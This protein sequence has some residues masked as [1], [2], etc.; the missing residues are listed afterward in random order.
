[1]SS[2]RWKEITPSQ[3][4]WEREALAFVRERLP[5][6]E[7]YRAWSNFEFIAQDGSIYEVDLLVLTPKGFFLVEIKSRPGT[8]DG[9]AGT[10][11]WTDGGRSIVVDNPL[12]L[13][14][15]KAK[16]LAT[17]LRNQRAVDRIPQLPFLGAVMFLSGNVQCRL[18]G[19]ARQGAHLRDVDAADGRPD[20]PGI[21]A[22][23]AYQTPEEFR[24]QRLRIDRPMAKAISLA[25]EQAGI[26]PS[27]KYR[28]V[29]DFQLERALGDGPGYQD[30]EAK[31][32]A[33]RG[34][35]RRVRLYTAG[36]TLDREAV[37]R[38]ADR[39]MRLLEGIEHPGIL[40]PV[41]YHVHELG[42][43]LVFEHDPKAV[44]L[45]H[46]VHQQAA[47]L[48]IDLRLHLVREIAEALRYAHEKRLYHRALNPSSILVRDGDGDRPRIQ[49][50]NWQTAAKD[51]LGSSGHATAT[52]HLADLVEGPATAYLAPEALTDPA[53][54]GEALDVFS[55]GAISFLVL[56]GRAP[57]SSAIELAERV[58]EGKGLRI[59]SALDGAGANLAE[60]IQWAT[61]PSATSRLDSVREFL[62]LLDGVEDELTAPDRGEVKS[63]EEAGVG[64]RLDGGWLVKKRLGRGATAIVFL[65]E[66]DGREVVLKLANDASQNDRIVDEAALLERL[67]HDRIVAYRGATEVAGRKGILMDKAGDE[68]LAQRLRS[69]GP[70]H[71]DL[72]QRFGEDLLEVV[73][74]L[75]EKAIP[76]RDIKP[77]NLGIAPSGSKALHLVL[78]DFS[79]SKTPADRIRAGTVPAS[80]WLG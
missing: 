47:R 10:W 60:L 21:V 4:P 41:A 14:N 1:M 73:R 5:D 72:L 58:R 42:P 51:S 27:R 32:S 36:S 56:S 70:L 29:G 50:F 40:R 57:A 65:V 15:R 13:A 45:D 18:Q 20:A 69:D 34:L 52:V 49:L 80:D 6:H 16:K 48:G 62:D 61:H 59:A 76:H 3:F 54:D 64:D 68:T 35:T 24:A 11:T 77:E 67:R 78:F 66:R 37:S 25:M 19:T 63:P 39:E 26:R 43:A 53:A 75:G 7:P 38:A 74:H 33:V 79:L 55:L 17:L 2:D 28:T 23:V 30:W 9:D 71:I 31:H 12:I 22:A 8:V 46:Y 44:R